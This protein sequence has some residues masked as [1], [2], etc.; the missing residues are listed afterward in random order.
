LGLIQRIA[1]KVGAE[2]D[3]HLGHEPS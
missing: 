3:R 2:A 1:K